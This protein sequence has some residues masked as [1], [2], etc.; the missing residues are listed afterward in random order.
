[1][2]RYSLLPS[3]WWGLV[4]G[5]ALPNLRENCDGIAPTSV[6]SWNIFRSLADFCFPPGKVT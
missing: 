2:Q 1:M 6:V 3:S 4:F 5:L